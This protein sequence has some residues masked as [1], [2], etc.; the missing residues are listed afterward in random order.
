MVFWDRCWDTSY[1]RDCFGSQ[2][3]VEK[4]VKLLFLLILCIFSGIAGRAGGS[5]RFNRLWRVI[6]VPF[7]AI[8]AVWLCFG[9]RMAYFWAYLLSFGLMAASVST[10][11]D[12]LFGYDEHFFHGFMIGLSLAP[13]AWVT[14]HWLGFCLAVILSTLWMGFWS[15]ILKWDV[16]EEF[17]RY[18]IL[19]VVVLVIV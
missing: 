9:V 13:I 16:A 4:D 11:W 18:F 6:G 12:F 3:K 14:G 19:P 15:K 1:H 17:G 10:Y 5:G 2:E 8:V 7:L